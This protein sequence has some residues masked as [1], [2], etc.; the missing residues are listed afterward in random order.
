VKALLLVVGVLLVL[1]GVHWIGQGT[2]IFV[3][4]A[5]P[6]MDNHVEW[7]YYGGAAGIA[8][9]LLIW[10]SRRRAGS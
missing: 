5:N 7:A 4:P 1:L 9:V 3:W 2:G 10:F 6:V 8:G